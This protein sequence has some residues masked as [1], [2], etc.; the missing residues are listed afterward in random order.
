M[1]R[2]NK[3]QKS[4]GCLRARLGWQVLVLAVALMS[5]SGV[6]SAAK[7]GNGKG[8]GNG[9]NVG[10]DVSGWIFIDAVLDDHHLGDLGTS[11]ALVSDV[12]DQNGD[13]VPYES[14]VDRVEAAVGRNRNIGINL[15]DHKK[16]AS[17]RKFRFQYVDAGGGLVAGFPPI[18]VSCQATAPICQSEKPFFCAPVPLT[19]VLAADGSAPNA[20]LSIKGEDHDDSPVRCVRHVN[21][22]LQVTDVDGML[23]HVYFGSRPSGGGTVKSPCASCVTV[24]RLPNVDSADPGFSQ[25]QVSTEWPHTAYLF[26]DDNPPHAPTEY[27]G[28]VTLPFSCVIT[29]QSEEPVPDPSGDCLDSDPC[30]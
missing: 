16:K 12:Y 26:R 30:P 22:E 21:A 5:I 27:H 2:K 15:N 25:W 6:A 17:I 11:N 1:L 3:N 13:P 28:M 29:S 24:D 4:V 18:D 7:G 23:W 14:N 8:G 10:G 20:S 9:G 19:P